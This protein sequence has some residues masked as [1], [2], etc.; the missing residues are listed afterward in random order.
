MFL[1]LVRAERER[2]RLWSLNELQWWISAEPLEAYRPF[3]TVPFG[4]GLEATAQMG[5]MLSHIG[6]DLGS[7]SASGQPLLQKGRA[8]WRLQ[9]LTTAN[10]GT[11]KPASG[12]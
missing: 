2:Q 5:F 9:Q 1:R 6:L 11:C 8:I 7:T 3:L 10:V 4:L 12:Y